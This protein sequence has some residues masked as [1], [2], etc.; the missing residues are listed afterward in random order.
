MAYHKMEDLIPYFVV[1]FF[2]YIG[3]WSGL[4]RFVMVIIKIWEK[5]CKKN[6]KN[7]WH[8]VNPVILYVSCLWETGK[9]NIIKYDFW[10]DKKV[11]D[12]QEQRWYDVKVADSDWSE[13]YKKSSEKNKKSS[14]Q[15]KWEMIKYKSCR[16]KRQERTLTTEQ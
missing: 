7:S 11:L 16:K 13:H 9:N 1:R 14:W 3:N 8:W 15:K 2:C 12:K 4:F 5:I 6:Q 10:K